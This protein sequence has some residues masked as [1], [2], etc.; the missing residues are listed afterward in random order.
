MGEV[1]DTVKGTPPSKH[2][3]G[4]GDANIVQQL[5]DLQATLSDLTMKKDDDTMVEGDGQMAENTRKAALLRAT[6]DLVTAGL[7]L[8]EGY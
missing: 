4:N 8:M 2:R 3:K 1:K 5:T 7:T 6:Y